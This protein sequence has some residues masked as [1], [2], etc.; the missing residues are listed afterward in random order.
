[1]TYPPGVR[2]R[3][4]IDPPAA[5]WVTPHVSALAT[6]RGIDLATVEGHGVGGRIRVTDLP[7]EATAGSALA[8]GNRSVFAVEADLTALAAGPYLPALL[9][10]VVDAGQLDEYPVVTRVDGRMAYLPGVRDLNEDGIAKL[11]ADPAS[12]KVDPAKTLLV[13]E[14]PGALF[15][16]PAVPGWSGP[17]LA[18][19]AAVRRPA[20]VRLPGGGEGLAIRTIAQL[21][22]SVDPLV[23]DEATALAF[24]SGLR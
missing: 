17:I 23:I 14:V 18:L 8:A 9:K 15:A 4:D 5:P 2:Y 13:L 11:L 7:A 12:A 19:G 10:A 16:A 20:V 6:E 1:M 21:T 22:L 3:T 24:L